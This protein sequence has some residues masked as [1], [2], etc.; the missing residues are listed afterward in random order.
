M[1][2]C[3]SLGILKP[4]NNNKIV[5]LC[6]ARDF[7]AM[8]WYRSAKEELNN[9]NVI[10]LTDLIESEGYKNLIKDNDNIYDLLII[11]KILFKKQSRIGDVF[12]LIS[13]SY[14]VFILFL[15]MFMIKYLSNYKYLDFKHKKKLLYVICVLSIFTFNNAILWLPWVYFSMS[16]Y[17]II[18]RKKLINFS[19]T[20]IILS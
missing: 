8:D 3:L 6:G 9:E 20:N 11:D 19:R 16:G 1:L 17:I 18:Q 14:G 13:C 5:F 12:T 7:H 15:W 10:V 2:V 4:M